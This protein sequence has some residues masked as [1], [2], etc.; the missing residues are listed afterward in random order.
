MRSQRRSARQSFCWFGTTFVQ[1][2]GG[3]TFE[4]DLC[5]FFLI[6]WKSQKMNWFCYRLLKKHWFCKQNEAIFVQNIKKAL[7][8]WGKWSNLGAGY[9]KRIGFVNKMKQNEAI[10]VQNITKKKRFHTENEGR[11]LKTHWFYQENEAILVRNIKKALV[12]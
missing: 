11:I 12:L 9:W 6:L 5:L 10:F 3:G 8:L 1:F 4:K 7:V 2:E